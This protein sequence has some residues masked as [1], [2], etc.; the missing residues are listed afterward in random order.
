MMSGS[1]SD[2]F[3][4]IAG[5]QHEPLRLL[6]RR[7]RRIRVLRREVRGFAVQL[8]ASAARATALARRIGRRRRLR[9]RRRGCLAPLGAHGG[10]E[11]E[12]EDRQHRGGERRPYPPRLRTPGFL[13]HNV[14]LSHGNIVAE[15]TRG[16]G[17]TLIMPQLHST[18]GNRAAQDPRGWTS[19]RGASALA[20][21]GAGFAKQK[22]PRP[23]TSSS[24]RPPAAPDAHPGADPPTRAR[25]VA[26]LFCRRARGHHIHRSRLHLTGRARHSP[27]SR[28]VEDRDGLG[29]L[30]LRL[31]LRAVRDPG[32]LARRSDRAATRADA[33]RRLV[34]VLHRRHRVGLEPRLAA[35]HADR[36]SAPA[37]P[38]AFP[39]M[40]RVFTTWL[41]VRERERAQAI[42][43]ARARAGAARSRRCW[44]PTS[45]SSSRGGAPSSCSA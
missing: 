20:Y 16:A 12:E 19:R 11:V 30:G 23:M 22:G 31:G 24:S 44:W 2:Q 4:A 26:V 42:A 17:C 18:C 3:H 1:A 43:V 13:R 40:T 8:S 9:R 33:D 32:R 41:P 7:A 38:A 35:R 27:G 39:N 14:G 10:V 34:V 45:S 25:Y 15:R 28:A 29:V 21:H 37:R 36:S 6:G 5:R